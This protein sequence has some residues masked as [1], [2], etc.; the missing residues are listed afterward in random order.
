MT[1]LIVSSFTIIQQ[2]EIMG[3]HLS[4]VTR[5]RIRVT[6]EDVS[7]CLSQ[8]KGNL[9]LSLRGIRSSIRVRVN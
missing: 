4:G 9:V 1:S 6:G 3:W 8:G 5:T 2:E 7:E